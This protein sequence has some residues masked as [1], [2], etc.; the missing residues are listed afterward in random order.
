MVFKKVSSSY[1]LKPEL[2]APAGDWESLQAAVQNGAD[3]IYLGG[4]EFNARVN[5]KNFSSGDLGRAVRYCHEQGVKVYLTMNT[6]VKNSEMQRYFD[7]LSSAYSIGIDGVIVQH[8]SFVEI[9]KKNY[10]D[11]AVFVST[12]GAIGNTASASILKAADRIILPREMS[13]ADIKRMV[14]AGIKVEVFVH[15]ALCFSY[16][17]LCLF[18]SFVDGRSGNRGCCAQLCRQ[19]FNNQ[20]PL[21][22]K[23][24]CLVNRI[25]E[26]IK[27][28]VTA[29]KIEGRM[30]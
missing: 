18:S 21:S 25:P 24:L 7:T 12:Q 29:F 10:L 8:L 5:A 27:A 4:R 16:S 20:Y 19:K 1:S 15:G 30:R 11:L 14:D 9:I 26:L 6:L 17:G 2:L 23:E 13:L 3:A 22:T 28:G